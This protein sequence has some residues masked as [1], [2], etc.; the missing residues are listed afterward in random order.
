MVASPAPSCW[1][2]PCPEELRLPDCPGQAG[3]RVLPASGI[4]APRSVRVIYSRKGFNSSVE[5]GKASGSECRCGC[6]TPS[7]DAARGQAPAPLPEDQGGEMHTREGRGGLG[8]PPQPRGGSSGPHC[9]SRGS[10]GQRNWDR[11]GARGCGDGDRGSRA[12]REA[13]PGVA[14]GGRDPR[15]TRDGGGR[16]H[17]TRSGGWVGATECGGW[18]LGPHD[19]SPAN[20]SEDKGHCS[21]ISGARS[22]GQHCPGA[23]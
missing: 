9:N 7:R 10:G 21:G 16:A 2:Q 3:Q 5:T 23:I 22:R 1:G 19:P 6:R 18:P 14:L 12:G 4:Q 8:P 17:E 20:P 11:R 13:T 15:R